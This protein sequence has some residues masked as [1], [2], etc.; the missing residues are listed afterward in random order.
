MN[1]NEPATLED[2]RTMFP[3]TDGLR[4]AGAPIAIPVYGVGNPRL[5]VT[6]RLQNLVNWVNWLTERSA[7]H[8]PKI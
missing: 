4:T 3:S 2:S 5:R 6:E 1:S 8:L 7:V